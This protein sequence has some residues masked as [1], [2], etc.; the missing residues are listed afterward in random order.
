MATSVIGSTQAFL[1]RSVLLLGVLA[2]IA[3]VFGMHLISGPHSMHSPA[4]ATPASNL[5]VPAHS[6]SRTSHHHAA[7]PP[8]CV[9]QGGCTEMSAVHTACTPAPAS[10]SLTAAFSL[11][12]QSADACESV[13]AYSYVPAGP[14]P[15]GL[16]ISRT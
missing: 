11:H 7:A 12:D 10:A 5:A 2:I 13:G 14:T 1:R 15:G 9:D 8:S 3:G 6:D 16:S 4:A